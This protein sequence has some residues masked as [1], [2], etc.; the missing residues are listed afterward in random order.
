MVRIWPKFWTKFLSEEIMFDTELITVS[1]NS[2][3]MIEI[4]RT[5]YPSGYMQTTIVIIKTFGI[6]SSTINSIFIPHVK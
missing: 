6:G 5:E 2:D 4:W 3:R 1:R